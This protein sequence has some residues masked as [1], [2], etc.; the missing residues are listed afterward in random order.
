MGYTTEFEGRFYFLTPL[1]PARTR[2]LQQFSQTRRMKRDP[3][4]ASQLPDPSREAVGLPIGAEGGYY[5]GGLERWPSDE[6]SDVLNYNEP[7]HGQ[8]GLWCGWT[9]EDGSA[10]VWNGVE[11]FYYYVKWLRYLIEHFVEPWGCSING[12]VTWQ[13]EDRDDLGRIVVG[14]NKVRVFHGLIVIEYHEV[15]R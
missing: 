8:P 15:D 7:P 2:Y 11:K 1:S 10:I 13:G 6:S 4:K 3:E 9:T 12:E 5:V 14:A